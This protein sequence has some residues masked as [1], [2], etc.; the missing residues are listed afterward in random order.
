MKEGFKR[1]TA[2][3][4]CAAMLV[5]YLPATEYAETGEPTEEI[6]LP[7]HM[8]KTESASAAAKVPLSKAMI[9]P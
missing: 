5:G 6:M 4:L 7:M 3:C 8:V 1:L 2:F 9:L